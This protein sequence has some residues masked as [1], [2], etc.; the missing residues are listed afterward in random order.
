MNIFK[1][2]SAILISAILLSSCVEIH[3]KIYLN[4]DGTGT[5][6]RELD[7]RLLYRVVSELDSTGKDLANIKHFVDSTMQALKARIGATAGISGMQML[8]SDDSSLYTFRF[9]F[10]NIK[11][12]NQA[13][14]NE[15]DLTAPKYFSWKKGKLSIM[16]GIPGLHDPEFTAG[17]I[18]DE[19]ER[20][21]MS[22]ATYNIH[23]LAG[24]RKKVS[25]N[26]KYTDMGKEGL[27]FSASF[28]DI[29]YHPGMGKT[30]IKYK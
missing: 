11:A 30:V 17:I 22:T 19:E 5:Y 2:L 10:A 14:K 25:S 29:A 15:E 6:S 7:C 9:D 21:F 12:L 27:S 23:V 18:E 8:V 3:D 4:P 24:T 28:L 1:R 20:G 13:W 26:K 16:G